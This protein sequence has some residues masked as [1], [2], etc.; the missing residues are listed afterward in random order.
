MGRFSMLPGIVH[1]FLNNEEYHSLFTH[2]EIVRNMIFRVDDHF[3]V[4]ILHHLL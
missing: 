4:V 3:L 1:C 2:F